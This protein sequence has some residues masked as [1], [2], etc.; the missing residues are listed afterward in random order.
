MIIDKKRYDWIAVHKVKRKKEYMYIL[1]KEYMIY[2]D[3]GK[4][5]IKYDGYFGLQQGDLLPS[6]HG[7]ADGE[8]LTDDCTRVSYNKLPVVV[9]QH[10]KQ[11]IQDCIASQ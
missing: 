9:Q 3:N 1:V 8:Y 10:L 7:D 11:Y 5:R 6:D 4:N 2:A